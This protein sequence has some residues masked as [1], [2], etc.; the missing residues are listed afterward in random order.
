MAT[1]SDAHPFHRRRARARVHSRLRG[2][3]E[4]PAT[5]PRQLGQSHRERGPRR[6]SCFNELSRFPG[7]VTIP[8]QKASHHRAARRPRLASLSSSHA[9]LD[10]PPLSI[11]GMLALLVFFYL[12]GGMVRKSRA[13]GRGARW[14]ASGASSGLVHWMTATLFHYSC[15]LGPQHHLRQAAA[16]AADRA[17]GVHRMVAVGQIRRITISAS[18]SRMGVFVIFMMWIAWNIPELALRSNGL[19]RRRRDCRHEHPPADRFNGG[20]K[21]I[22]WIVVLGGGC[23]RGQ[24]ISC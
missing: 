13:G 8:D 5:Q 18:R 10:R 17:R 16:A 15:A 19:K 12:T 3:R 22:Y 21:M 1:H 7:A 2:A 14:C 6:V 4:R 11:L 23:D 24:R 20:Q 9:A